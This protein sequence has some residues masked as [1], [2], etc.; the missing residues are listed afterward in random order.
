M[1]VKEE[2]NEEEIDNDHNLFIVYKMR[3]MFQ[4]YVIKFNV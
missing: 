1:W 3:E 2:K 4:D